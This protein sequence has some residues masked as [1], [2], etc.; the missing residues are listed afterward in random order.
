MQLLSVPSIV[1]PHASA[2]INSVPMPDIGRSPRRSSI[3][4]HLGAALKAHLSFSL[5]QVY[6]SDQLRPIDIEGRLWCPDLWVATLAKDPVRSRAI[7]EPGLIVQV[8]SAANL[9]DRA[10]RLIAF[11]RAV[12]V[13]EIVAIDIPSRSVEIFQQSETRDPVWLVTD[14]AGR[15]EVELKTIQFTLSS[16]KLWRCKALD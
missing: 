1:L 8:F 4:K 5:E 6:S 2:V 15:F 16:E 9:S 13:R 14:H 3:V 11:R 10:R 7:V 12:G